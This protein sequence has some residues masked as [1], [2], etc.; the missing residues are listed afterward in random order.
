MVFVD[1]LTKIVRLAPLRTEISA[2]DVTDL[3]ISQVFRHHG[4]PNELVINRD[5]RFMSAFFRRLTE[6]WEV[7]QK[8]ST[9]FHLQTDG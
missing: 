3:L 7:K 6:K 9:S 1:R 2:S 4:L 5:T 8:M